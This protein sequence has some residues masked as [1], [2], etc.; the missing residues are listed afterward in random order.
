VILI[1]LLIV[2][3][4]AKDLWKGVGQRHKSGLED[5]T[6]TGTATETTSEAKPRAKDNNTNLTDNKDHIVDSTD[7]CRLGMTGRTESLAF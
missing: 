2:Q 7:N 5:S 3:L 4:G 1:F 6:T